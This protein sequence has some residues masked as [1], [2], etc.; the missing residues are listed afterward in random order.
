MVSKRIL[1]AL[2]LVATLVLN[3]A[4]HARDNFP[5]LDENRQELPVINEQVLRWK[6]Q[7]PNQYQARARIRGIIRDVYPNRN[8]HYHFNAL[9]GPKEKDTIEVVYNI[10]F[11]EVDNIVP[12]LTVEACGD[13]ITS[14]APT[15]VYQPSPD[16]AI[17]HWIHR[18]PN[19]RRH[20]H[21]YMKIN[22]VLY[23]QGPGNR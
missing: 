18:S 10:S 6:A 13:Y 11:G 19:T 17:I 3:S 12:G 23:G 14:N 22:D 21:G 15:Q 5:C 2:I 16:G 8:G 9:I 20:L 1:S 4:A 7:T